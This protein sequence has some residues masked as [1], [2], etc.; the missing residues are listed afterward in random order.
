MHGL[1]KYTRGEYRSE[2]LKSSTWGFVREKYFQDGLC[3]KCG[4]EKATDLHHC[5]YFTNLNS[6]T[7]RRSLMSLCRKCH[8]QVEKAKRL[9]LLPVNH[10]SKDVMKLN[11]NSI[12]PKKKRI[13]KSWIEIIQGKSINDQRIVAGIIK[14]KVPNS[15]E[16]Y[17]SIHFPCSV[18]MKMNEFLFVTPADIMRR[19]KKPNSL[20]RIQPGDERYDGLVRYAFLVMI[21]SSLKSGDLVIR[22]HPGVTFKQLQE[23]VRWNDEDYQEYRSARPERFA[24]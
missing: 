23:L 6:E 24:K 12:F 1:G 2:F 8:Q 16:E 14:M 18:I 4:S 5:N 21:L 13:P 20:P 7:S 22:K 17:S 15:W 9:G 3:Q 10:F 11:F 19:H